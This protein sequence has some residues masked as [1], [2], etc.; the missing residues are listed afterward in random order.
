MTPITRLTSIVVA[1]AFAIGGAGLALASVGAPPVDPAAASDTTA[2]DTATD[3]AAMKALNRELAHL[4]ARS[5]RL[6]SLLGDLKGKTREV[7]ARTV[8]LRSTSSGSD[9]STSSSS[10]S[11]SSPAPSPQTTHSDD[12]SGSYDDDSSES[13]DDSYGSDDQSDEH[14]DG[15]V[16]D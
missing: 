6:H 8:A 16:D 7:S 2:V 1:A 12:S 3:P 4:D 9:D 11:S 15:G 13:D 14:E 10:P 5:K